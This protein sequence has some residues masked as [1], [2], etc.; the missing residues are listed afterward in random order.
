MTPTKPNKFENPKTP[1]TKNAEPVAAPESPKTPEIKNAEPAA[2]PEIP[3][4]E[5]SRKT[6]KSDKTRPGRRIVSVSIP[7]KLARQVKLLCNVTGTTTQALVE[8][9]LQRAV[10]KQLGAALEAIR[11]DAEG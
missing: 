5:A 6:E 4:A 8:A 11:P 1:E 3:Q 10:N 9:A 7:E 2:A